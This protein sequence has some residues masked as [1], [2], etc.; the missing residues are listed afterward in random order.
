MTDELIPYER[1]TKKHL[2]RI[3]KKQHKNCSRLIGQKIELKTELD[4]MERACDGAAEM[5]QDL[6]AAKEI[7]DNLLYY[8][9]Q[10][11][12]ER[13]NYAELDEDIKQAEQFLKEHA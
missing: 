10:C 5:Y 2:I 11:T 4:F 7:I 1:F 6:K 12:C 13:S 9:K 3:C 8:I